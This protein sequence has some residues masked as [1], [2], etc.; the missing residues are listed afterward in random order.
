MANAPGSE[1][2][3]AGM[4]SVLA[5]RG[6]RLA[7]ETTEGQV[8]YQELSGRGDRLA[9]ALLDLGVKRG[10]RF[11]FALPNGARIVECYLACARS[12]IVAVPLSERLSDAE[13]IYEV[14][15]AEAVA[16]LYA[17]GA[18]RLVEATRGRLPSVR[19]LISDA[20]Q[21]SELSVSALTARVSDAVLDVHPQ[22]Q[23]IFSVMYT[24]GTTGL[25]KA[26]LHTQQSWA[27]SLLTT[28]EEWRLNED[29]RHLVVL[30]MS[31]VSWFSTA[32]VLL[33][34]GTA[35]LHQGWDPAAVVEAVERER[36]TTLN[37]IPTMLGDLLEAIAA[38]RDS[39]L[40]SLRLVTVAGSPM[41]PEMYRRAHSILGP[42]VGNIYGLTETSGPVTYLL[43]EDLNDSRLRSG[44]R[45]GRFVQLAILGEEG[46][47]TDGSRPGEIALRGPQITVGYLNRPEESEQAFR[48]TWFL[49][50]DIG[51]IDQD[52][53]VY[54]VDRRKDMVKSGG[55]NVYPKEV[56]E[57]IYTH[58][59]VLEAAVFGVPDPRWIEA[60]HGAVVIQP[61]AALTED[62]LR[63]YCRNELPGYK[64]PKVIH[65]ERELP[66]TPVGKFDKAN[67]K[68][69][70]EKDAAQA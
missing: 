57:V 44:G 56:E 16:L 55:Y 5:S 12:G 26:A 27:A 30:P 9:R 3:M 61:G 38:R 42:I 45:A 6:E 66:R 4:M 31:H 1:F 36:I 22:P 59:D 28:V 62:L 11:A 32:S 24:G 67:L 20:D 41:P 43:P 53:F 37:M 33:A 34:G 39:D 58:P 46:E 63:A 54:I 15:D 49:T 29:D 23:D 52:G 65:F 40:S 60:V 19:W 69:R 25:S 35:Y 13:F 64:V 51:H 48:N 18:R 47:V 2:T 7:L 17:V 8:S 14:D 21:E 68:R 10:E 50:G 70:Y